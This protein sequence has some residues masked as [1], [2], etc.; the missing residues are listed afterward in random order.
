MAHKPLCCYHGDDNRSYSWGA[1]VQFA[2]EDSHYYMWVAVMVNHCTISNWR[3]NSEVQLARSQ[4]GPLGPFEKLQDVILP[5]AH[6]PQTI[7]TPDSQAKHGY[8][9]AVYTLGDGTPKSGPPVVCNRSLPELRLPGASQRKSRTRVS[10]T[11]TA[12][13]TIHWAE[14]ARGPYQA[15]NA[16]I[17]DWPANWDY[18]AN[19]NWNPSPFQHP[20]GSVYLMAH[21]SWR[22]FC[23]EAII[24]ADHW[25][26]P[27][28]VVAADTYANW[29]GSA[30][31]VEDPFLWMDKR[32]HWHALYHAMH[33]G[34]GGHAFSRDGLTWSN[35]SN[36]YSSARPLLG[37]RT[38]H[39]NAERP[40]LLLG[41]DAT[42][43]HLYTG[44]DKRSGFT[45]VSPLTT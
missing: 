41:P 45:I 22:A 40:K 25:R 18:G 44:S 6:N 10:R 21:T 2:P 11:I 24:R 20:N 28:T 33:V 23:G 30:C 43:T 16:S 8:V 1:S 32:Q 3:T 27:Y 35:V 4:F 31:K 7:R 9:Y 14:E 19:G 12:N 34:P 36:A 38:V 17:L 39:Y 5:W 29:G 26:G 15:F 37:N 13:F 42:P